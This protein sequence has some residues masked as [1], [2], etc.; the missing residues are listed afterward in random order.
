MSL[1]CVMAWIIAQINTEQFLIK[2]NIIHWFVHTHFQSTPTASHGFAAAQLQFNCMTPAE[3][4]PRSAHATWWHS[5]QRKKANTVKT[6][7]HTG[8][9]S[10]SCENIHANMFTHMIL[11]KQDPCVALKCPLCPINLFE[12]T[13][14]YC[15][16]LIS[17]ERI[18]QRGK[19]PNTS[20]FHSKVP[21]EPPC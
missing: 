13:Q 21:G 2:G 6:A 3:W 9:E 10:R 1:I 8:R 7:A 16:F 20:S 17:G 11:F 19:K 5:E 4:H 12:D 18:N 14:E 15:L